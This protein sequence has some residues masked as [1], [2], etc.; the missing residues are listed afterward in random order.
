MLEALT[1][2]CA[3]CGGSGERRFRICDHL[4]GNCPCEGGV[5]E[6]EECEGTGSVRCAMCGDAPAVSEARKGGLMCGRCA[7]EEEA[8]NT[9]SDG[10]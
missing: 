9:R 4:H 10:R 3:T 1:F 5:A 2:P 8:L 6:C 7:E